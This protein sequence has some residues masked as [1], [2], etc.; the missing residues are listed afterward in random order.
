MGAKPTNTKA[1]AFLSFARGDGASDAMIASEMV[2]PVTRQRISILRQQWKR[3]TRPTAIE[4]ES[5]NGAE[6]SDATDSTK[7]SADELQGNSFPAL[8]PGTT[9]VAMPAN[10]LERQRLLDLAPDQQIEV[11]IEKVLKGSAPRAAAIAVGI[12]SKQFSTRMESDPKFRD[13][14][15]RASSQAEG[16]VAENLYTQATGRSPQSVQAAIAWLEKRHP[17]LWGR[18]AMRVEIEHSGQVDV[19]H[20]LADP[21]RIIEVNRHEAEL[22]R[23]EDEA[24][25]AEYRELP[26]HDAVPPLP[27]NN[28]DSGPVPIRVEDSLRSSVNRVPERVPDPAPGQQQGIRQREIMVNGVRTLVGDERSREDRPPF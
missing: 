12:T 4:S 14:V 19:N 7:A 10:A 11:M 17:D 16:S 22:Q 15:L 21:R 25:D 23:L 20:I 6:S 18:E 27:T 2:P 26:A 1:N 9:R 13:L 5:D 8:Y 28:D 24:T 3:V